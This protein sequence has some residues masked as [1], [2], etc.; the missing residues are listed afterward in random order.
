LA[1]LSYLASKPGNAMKTLFSALFFALLTATVALAQSANNLAVSVSDNRQTLTISVDGEQN[2]KPL[3]FERTY[4]VAALSDSARDA[5]K[6]RIL[7]SLGLAR[8]A[9]PLPPNVPLSPEAT[10]AKLTETKGVLPTAVTLRCEACTGRMRLEVAGEGYALART[11]SNTTAPP[12]PLTISLLPGEYRY[13]YWQNGVLQMQL[14]FTVK[15]GQATTV[16]VRW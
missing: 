12:F 3:R 6:T 8:V 1:R 4:N 11:W 10:A 13:Q 7:D 9:A 15:A 16:D 2:G 14:P 5:L